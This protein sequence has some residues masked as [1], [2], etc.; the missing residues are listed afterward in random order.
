MIQFCH[1]IDVLAR[2]S[3]TKALVEGL[4]RILKTECNDGTNKPVNNRMKSELKKLYFIA[5]MYR[6][7]QQWDGLPQNRWLTTNLNGWSFYRL[8]TIML[9]FYE[10]AKE[11]HENGYGD[12]FLGKKKMLENAANANNDRAEEIKRRLDAGEEVSDADR[13][14]YKA[15][16]K[17]QENDQAAAVPRD[18]D[19]WENADW[20]G[21]KP[22]MDG[23]FR[24]GDKGYWAVRIDNHKQSKTWCWWTYL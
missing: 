23:K 15:Y 10:E 1:P 6:Q 8:R 16:L 11:I 17:D 14:W 4:V 9:P 20:N 7:K 2:L 21:H 12:K 18:A 3:W 22:Y 24:I 19:P 5:T 13:E